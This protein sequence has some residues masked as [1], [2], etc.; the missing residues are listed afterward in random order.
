MSIET[1]SRKYILL[2]KIAARLNFKWKNV[3][4]I[5][6]SSFPMGKYKKL[7]PDREKSIS[8]FLQIVNSHD[9]WN[10]TNSISS[11]TN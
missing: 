11:C 4:L 2:L 8:V 6:V 9:F 3:N 5:G 1:R 7:I 10:L